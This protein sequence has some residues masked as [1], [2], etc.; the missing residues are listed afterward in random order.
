MNLPIA[1]L[2]AVVLLM[3]AL[4]AAFTSRWTI[5]DSAALKA[6][7][8]NVRPG[9]EQRYIP[10]GSILG[11]VCCRTTTPF[12]VSAALALIGPGVA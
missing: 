11:V 9:L 10:R 5:F 1:R 4:L 8:L 6:N 12:E 7:S 2:F 3:F